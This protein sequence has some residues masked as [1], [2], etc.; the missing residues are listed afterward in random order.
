MSIWLICKQPAAWF[1]GFID[2]LLN[3]DMRSFES[4]LQAI[5]ATIPS[6]R[7]LR[8]DYHESFYQGLML[9]LFVVLSPEKYQ[10][11]SR[12]EGRDGYYDI[13]IVPTSHDE[14]VV[15]LELKAVKFGQD[16]EKKSLDQLQNEAQAALEQIDDKGYTQSFTHQGYQEIIKIGISFSSKQVAVCHETESVQQ[17]LVTSP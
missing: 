3:G 17:N 12:G 13:A 5:V 16:N 6:H 11:I 14:A 4:K 9:G 8:R 1:R 7:D 2:S 10:V 15:V